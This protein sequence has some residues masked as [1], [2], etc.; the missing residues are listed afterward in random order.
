MS[1]IPVVASWLSLTARGNLMASIRTRKRSDGSIGYNVV[2]IHD[3]RQTSATFDTQPAAEQFLDS[4]RLLGAD[5]AMTAFGI[6]PTVR[7]GG[8]KPSGVTVQKWVAT[9]IASRT[10]VAKS[11]VYDY[12]A[13]LRNDIT[14]YPIGAIPIEL[15]NRDDVVEWV[16]G[17]AHLAG[18]TI[19]NKHGLLSAALNAAVRAGIIPSNPAV[20]IRLPRSEQAE[21][22]FLT[23]EEFGQLLVGFTERWRPLVE[24]MVLSGA[25]FGEIS[26]LQPSDVDQVA[27]TVRISRARKRTYEKGNTYEVGPTKTQRSVRTINV[28]TS[29]LERLDYTHEWLFTN[30]RGGPLLLAGWRENV[31][32]KSVARAQKHG[33]VKAP[34]VHDMR[35]TCA[36]WMIQGGVPLPV[37]QAHLGH[38]AINTTVQLYSHLDRSSHQQAA[39]AIAAAMYGTA[40]ADASPVPGQPES[41]PECQSTD[42]EAGSSG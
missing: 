30:T 24:F 6:T 32:Y 10:G 33:L 9:Y 18:K 14:P 41:P 25:R 16:Q 36:S 23:R 27:G 5:R 13:V 35:H 28:A 17:M 40:A 42:S 37:V 7:A 22:V 39:D 11:T 1:L 4:V 29:L 19:V 31:W 26:A 34:R 2:Y 21:M 8:T 20:G 15:L 38:E 12:E 3:G